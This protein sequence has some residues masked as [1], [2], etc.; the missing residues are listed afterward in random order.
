MLSH[1]GSVQAIL[2]NILK[3]VVHRLCHVTMIR[4]CCLSQDDLVDPLG[5]RSSRAGGMRVVVIGGLLGVG[6]GSDCSCQ[7]SCLSPP[8]PDTGVG[9]ELHVW[10]PCIA[11]ATKAS[12]A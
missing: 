1:Y 9:G 12:R 5:I 7:M 2:V 10:A 4:W 3:E 6:E 8:P 11:I